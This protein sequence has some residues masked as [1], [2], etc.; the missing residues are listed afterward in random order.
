MREVEQVRLVL[1]RSAYVVLRIRRGEDAAVLIDL[2]V[3][4][5]AEEC[6]CGRGEVVVD[7]TDDV[8]GVLRNSAAGIGWSCE[9]DLLKHREGCR[10]VGVGSCTQLRVGDN[11]VG[12]GSVFAVGGE[13]GLDIWC[14][15]DEELRRGDKS[16]LVGCAADTDKLGVAEEE[17]LVLDDG[18]ADLATELVTGVMAARNSVLCVVDSVGGQVRDA[19]EAVRGSVEGIGAGLGCD[20]DDAARCTTVLG[21]EVRGDDAE[22]LHRIEGNEDADRISEDA[23][24]FY[25]VQE[26]F[27]AGSAL[28]IEAETDAT[29]GGVLGHVVGASVAGGDVAGDGDEVVGIAGERR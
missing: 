5:V 20:V 6:L 3:I 19:V 9:G 22:L 4:N 15:L 26:D 23:E 17:E 7:A 11:R 13:E 18:T 25:A 12:S 27:R 29:G 24:I 21:L 28:P 1:V 10:E 8:V 2:V 14:S 16:S